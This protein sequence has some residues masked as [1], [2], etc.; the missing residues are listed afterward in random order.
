[1][2]KQSVSAVTPELQLPE[3]TWTPARIGL[4]LTTRNAGFLLLVAL[5][6]AWCWRPLTT[7]IG[8]SL[9]SA[10]Y[11]HYSHII[12]LP[13]FSA[14]LLYLNRHAIFKHVHPGL[15]TGLFLAA[16]GAATIWLGGSPVITGEPEHQ[17][18]MTML[19]LVTLWAGGFGLCYGHRALRTAA[20]PFLLL[21]FMV[22]LPPAVLTQIIV[23]LQRTSAD[24]S[25]LLFTLIGMPNVRQGFV[26]ALPGLTIE[27]AKECSGIR[28]SLALLIS[29]LVMAYLLLR[30]T[31]TRA[32]FVLTII[33]LA[34]AKNAVRIV[35]LSWLAVH[36]DPSFI[37]GSAVHRNGGIP[38]FLTSLAI[39]G[40]L[41]WLLRKCELRRTP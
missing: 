21:L 38:I 9:E 40:A 15:R 19:G 1:M 30:S 25:A 41:A 5:S 27:V 20:F 23:F 7:V 8:R 37:T 12:L 29:G 24:A 16:A 3:P 26:F 33:P 4:G 28:S 22:P 11:E 2:A 17:L 34:I 39:L 10:E 14:Y 31:W 35:V 36:I 13:F 6:V 32:A 18:S